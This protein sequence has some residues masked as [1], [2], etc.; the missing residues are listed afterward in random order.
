M[1][2][3]AADGGLNWPSS[4]NAGIGENEVVDRVI[5]RFRVDDGDIGDYWG[6]VMRTEEVKGDVFSIVRGC[7]V[8]KQG[9]TTDVGSTEPTFPSFSNLRQYSH[10]FYASN[11][12]FYSQSHPM[13]SPLH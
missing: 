1:P 3:A 9:F 7:R 12:V 11:L 2:V 5:F 4:G 10:S 8:N 6:K 13:H